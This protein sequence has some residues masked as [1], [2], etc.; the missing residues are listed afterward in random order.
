MCEPL[1]FF[2]KMLSPPETR[3]STFDRELLGIKLTIEHFRD[4]VEG[5]RFIVFTDHPPYQ[6]FEHSGID[7]HHVK[8]VIWLMSRNWQQTF[9]TSP[10]K[11]T[12]Y[13]M[14]FLYQSISLEK[15]TKLQSCLFTIKLRLSSN[16]YPKPR[17]PVLKKCLLIANHN[18]SPTAQQGLW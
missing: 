18:W 10:E 2:S 14:H 4:M 9:D 8:L 13:L 11:T 3:Y 7:H 5:R 17:K 15:T 12:L 6:L 1:G 16:S